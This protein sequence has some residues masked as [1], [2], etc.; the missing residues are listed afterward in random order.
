MG[1]VKSYSFCNCT[2]M[3][4]KKTRDGAPQA[5]LSAMAA[6][7]VGGSGSLANDQFG[8]NGKFGGVIFKALEALQKDT[9]RA[10]AHVAQR[11]ANGCE[12][13]G[14]IARK[15]NVVKADD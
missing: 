4:V 15:L 6:R 13:R 11:L 5:P 14:V 2:C 3:I 1:T 8:R 12:A 7:R 10:G 9:C